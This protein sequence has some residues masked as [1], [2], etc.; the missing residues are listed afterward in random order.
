MKQGKKEREGERGREG[1]RGREGGGEKHQLVPPVL[2][3]T[4]TG[5]PHVGVQDNAPTK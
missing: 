4:G 1:Q 2:V 3:L 5:P